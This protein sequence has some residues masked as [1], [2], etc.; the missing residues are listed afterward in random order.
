MGSTI[1]SSNFDF[2]AMKLNLQVLYGIFCKFYIYAL[3]NDINV[4]DLPELLSFVNKFFV[5]LLLSQILDLS[6]SISN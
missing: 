4:H 1:S 3:D 5:V 6:W 2:S